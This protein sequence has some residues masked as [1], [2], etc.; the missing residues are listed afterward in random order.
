M[1]GLIGTRA[2]CAGAAQSYHR[3]KREVVDVHAGKAEGKRGCSGMQEG[4]DEG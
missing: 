2:A 1:T 3:G 4:E